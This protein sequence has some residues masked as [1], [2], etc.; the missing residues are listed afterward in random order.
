MPLVRMWTVWGK[1][2]VATMLGVGPRRELVGRY[3]VRTDLVTHIYVVR[4]WRA[5]EEINV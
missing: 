5:T 2:L 4:D 1:W 3:Q